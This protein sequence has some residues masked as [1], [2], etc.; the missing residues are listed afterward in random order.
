MPADTR[1]P[2]TAGRPFTGRH[3]L[4]WLLGFFGTM[5]AANAVFIWLALDTFSGAVSDTAY[6]DG[7]AYNRRLEAAAAQQALRWNGKV[8]QHDRTVV[9]EL[10][11][12]K[13]AAVRALALKA[14]F[15]RP[16]DEGEDQVRPM[17][18]T[19]PGRYETQLDLPHSGNW[20]LV[21]GGT[22]PEGVV[23]ETRKRIRVR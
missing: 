2:F 10:Q 1:R 9:L 13:G 16:A 21:I 19:L 14:H 17:V 20:H 8:I 22:G 4:Y 7:L 23:F 3:L 11:D 5:F 6:Q 12:A 18:E 15:L